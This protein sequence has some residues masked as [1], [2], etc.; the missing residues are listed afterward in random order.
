[1]MAESG[2]KKSFNTSGVCIREKHYMVD[3]TRL[4]SAIRKMVEQGDYFVINRARQFGKT[5]TLREVAQLLRSKYVVFSI[6]LEGI[7]EAIYR[8][9]FSFCRGICRMLCNALKYGNSEMVSGEIAGKLRKA[10]KDTEEKTDFMAL[11]EL[12]SE[13]C[14]SS[15]KPIVLIIDEV[16]QA[17]GYR[18]FLDF[19][20]MLRNQ[21]LLRMEQPTF[22]SVILAG[23]H[24]IKNL[25]LGIRQ[26]QEHKYNS[27][28]NIAADFNVD[29]SFSE[30]DIAGMLSEYE[31]DYKTGM[32]IAEM[33]RLIFAYTS[34]YPYLVSRLCQILD[35]RVSG[36][37]DYPDKSAAWTREGLLE[38]VKQVLNEPNTLFDDM[39]KKI[40]EYPELREMLNALLFR[41]VTIPYNPDN[42]AIDIGVMFGFIT[43]REGSVDV[44]NRIFETRIYNMF[45][46]EELLNNVTYNEAIQDKNQFVQGT[47]LNMDLVMQKFAKHFAEVY[48][49]SEQKFIEENGRRLFLL[50]LKPIINGTGNYYV[51]ARTRDMR[52]TDIIVDYC[53]E[54]YI[55]EL[56]I[57]HGEEYNKRGRQ[58]LFE[59]LET[60]RKEKGYLLS[61]NFNKNKR[62]GV[63]EIEYQ[64]KRILEA[65]V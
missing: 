51:E 20:G 23:V 27:P 60:Y 46:S 54:Q 6:S 3:M 58:Q 10:S 24:D 59:Y 18:V 47:R 19:L 45:L 53:G 63:H 5:T 39:R 56:K 7:G 4:L 2:R 32:N 11:S 48:G 26:G 44:A 21:Y 36:M 9:E 52:R 62:T 57:W 28:W 1:M 16:D 38:A 13:M 29:M 35:E 8:D 37:T 41:G 61:F 65:V 17:S 43:Q 22:Q 64:G 14:D 49:D 12:F 55:I 15:E 40:A 42:Y 30:T 31:S 25:K 33:S 50:Y 34:G